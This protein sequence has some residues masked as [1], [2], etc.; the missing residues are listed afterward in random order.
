MQIDKK[1]GKALALS[2]GNTQVSFSYGVE[3]KCRVIVFMATHV[4]PKARN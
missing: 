3:Y 4:V 1:T 2:E